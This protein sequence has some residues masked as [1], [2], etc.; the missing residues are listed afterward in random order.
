M[1]FS[2]FDNNA[3]TKMDEE[4]LK[5]MLPFLQESY[6]NASA[7]QHKLGRQ[8]NGA[9]EQARIQLASAL[10]AQ[11]KE[12]FFTSGATES[13][14][15]V[16]QGIFKAYQSIGNHIISCASEHKAVVSSCQALA[17][18]GAKQTM[19]SCN[20]H[21]QIDLQELEAAIQPD[22]ILVSLMAANNET[23]LLHPIAE[24][25][26]I[27]QRKDVL[28][29]CDATQ[30]IGKLPLNLQAIPIDILCFSAHKFHG[31]KG[32]GALYIRR[33]SKPIQIPAMI[34]GGNQEHGFRGGTYAVP[35][36]VGMGEASRHF[37][38][39]SNLSE[40]RD[41]FESRLI[42]EVPEVSVHA[43]QCPR[44]PNT[45]NVLIKHVRSTELMTKLPDMA[46]SSGSA[47][48]S[49]S[50][51][52]SHVLKA[53]GL[54]DEDAYC[55]SRFSFSKYNTREEIDQAVQ[56]I[57][58]AVETIRKQSPIWQLYQEGLI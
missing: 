16:F 21:G 45:S 35:Q 3:T 12:I 52:P 48:V 25:A 57:K 8:A 53:M 44:T 34:L 5:A 23:G 19:L 1:G 26:D 24:I 33:K 10:N 50:R 20:N 58:A 39:N 13:I 9:I 46:F 30:H 55:S 18:Q 6:G 43:Q 32:I 17:K 31:P 47:C 49:G 56:Q 15:T 36:L 42:A 54:S 40:L 4:V 29:F 37:Q 41:Y 11:P 14:S 27:C 28:F 38:F 51:D 22:T 2:Y 7:V